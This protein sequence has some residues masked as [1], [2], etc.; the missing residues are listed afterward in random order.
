MATWLHWVASF[1]LTLPVLLVSSLVSG[2]IA[3]SLS[4]LLSRFCRSLYQI[5]AFFLVVL[6]VLAVLLLCVEAYVCAS[7]SFLFFCSFLALL[8]PFF[9]DRVAPYAEWF[10]N[11][12]FALALIAGFIFCYLVLGFF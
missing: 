4:G 3:G 8:I 5:V 2:L 12:Q 10:R 9:M 7:A 6:G 1:V 11:L